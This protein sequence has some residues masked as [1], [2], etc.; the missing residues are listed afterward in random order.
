LAINQFL[1]ELKDLLELSQDIEL[2][3]DLKSLDEYDSM[4]VMVLVAF[5]HKT[6]GK[7]FTAKELNNLT[8]VQSLVDLI[9]P[10]NF[11]S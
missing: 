9:G 11:T 5:I 8:T 7:R 1:E 10:E 6:F 2:N 4:G 3:T